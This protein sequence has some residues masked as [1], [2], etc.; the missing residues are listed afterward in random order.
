MNARQHELGGKAR[1]AL[2]ASVVVTFLLYV[3]PYGE[4][5]AYPLLLIS[6]VVHELGH[7]IA[8]ILSGGMFAELH[9]WADGSGVAYSASSGGLADAFVSAGGLCGPAVAAGVFLFL[10]RRPTWARWCLAAFGA[11]L[12]L[13][14]AVW[15]RGEFGMV[16]VG[17]LAAACLVTAF[18]ASA[19][20]A[21]LA[22]V[23]LATQLAL[24]VFSRGDYLFVRSASTGAGTDPSDVQQMANALGGPYWLWGAACGGFSVAVLAGAG[25]WYL[26]P[27]P[28]G[29]R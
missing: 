2:V 21:Q 25:W 7:G 24:S 22:L 28:R 11:F 18:V 16:F 13:A 9:M 23:F 12:G 19:E 29:G 5:V 27:T 1:T 17:G 8:A 14:L 3:V 6:T 15:V 20:V 26:R 10:G 4:Y